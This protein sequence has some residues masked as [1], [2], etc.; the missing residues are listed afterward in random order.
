VTKGDSSA[1]PISPVACGGGVQLRTLTCVETLG[2]K[3][4]TSKLCSS[5]DQL[6]TVQRLKIIFIVRKVANTYYMHLKKLFIF[7]SFLE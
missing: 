6:P 4:V 1:S 2:D 5:L 7:K 3:P